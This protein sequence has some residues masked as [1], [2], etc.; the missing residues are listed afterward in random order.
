MNKIIKS[1]KLE[2]PMVKIL[3]WVLKMFVK[4]KIQKKVN[5]FAKVGVFVRNV[6]K[7]SLQD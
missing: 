7:F 4:I 5:K 2:T 3:T 6:I 1:R